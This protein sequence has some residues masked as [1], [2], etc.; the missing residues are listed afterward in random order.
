MGQRIPL[1]RRTVNQEQKKRWRT[2]KQLT[3]FGIGL[4]L[5]LGLAGLPAAAQDQAPSNAATGSSDSLGSYARQVKK[6]GTP[7][8]KAKVFDNDNLPRE[9]KLSIVGP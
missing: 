9:D 2:M 5:S 8:A 7:K 4:V 6:D 1:P 3:T